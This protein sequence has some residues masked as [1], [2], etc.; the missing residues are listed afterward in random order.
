MSRRRSSRDCFVVGAG[1]A[2]CISP[3]MPLL[4]DLREP[5]AR[6]VRRRSERLLGTLERL[7]DNVELWMSYLAQP[8]PWLSD[9]DT[10]YNQSIF[11]RVSEEIASVVRRR[12]DLATS[13]PP[14]NWLTKL[15]ANWHA[16]RGLVLSLNYDMLI[17]KALYVSSHVANLHA[18]QIPIPPIDTR[19]GL[20][21][22]G[23]DPKP[24]IRLF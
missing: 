8:H 16:D 6:V 23:E 13:T 1:M 11:A 15:T 21:A 4:D 18:Y 22:Y 19:N 2:R 10:L 3:H 5:V 9:A 14:P 24:T 12:Q 7:G 17:E 20:T